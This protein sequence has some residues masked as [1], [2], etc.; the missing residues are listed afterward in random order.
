M[1][2]EWAGVM[3]NERIMRNDPKEMNPFQ[4]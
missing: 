4:Y 2:K 1:I 3:K